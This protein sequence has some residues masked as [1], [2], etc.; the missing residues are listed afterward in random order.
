[1]DYLFYIFGT[2]VFIATLLLAEAILLRWNHAKGPHAKIMARQKRIMTSSAEKNVARSVSIVK[3]RLL[4]ENPTLQGALQRLP[5]M[6]KL[7]SLLL[8][9]GLTWSVA[10]LGG[11]TML[12]TAA[13]LL[14]GM[15]LDLP[16]LLK[17][18]LGGL[19]V[20]LPFYIVTQA[21]ARR[22]RRIEQQL[23]DAL[24]LMS[25]AMRAGHA[26]PNALKMVGDEMSDP[27]GAEFRTAFDE[28]NFGIALSEAMQN[29]ARRVPST[30]LR[31]F[32]VAVL[33][34]RESGG[35]LSDLLNNISNLIRDRIK[36]L[37]QIRVLST[38]GRISGWVLS[39]LPFGAAIL[40]QLVNPEFLKILYMDPVGI[41]LLTGAVVLMGIGILVMRNIARIR[42]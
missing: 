3:K 38:E 6:A 15:H 42:V 1:M 12:A 4:S 41:E 14:A 27:L 10:R 13:S 37:G 28:V 24:D 11:L 34:Q 36:L 35:N 33:I 31:Y 26:F 16:L 17:L 8:Q 7:D 25:R 23:P 22:M 2:L 39:M 29:L 40:M 30:D 32:V 9:S 20:A 5:R 18:M 19:G 21:K